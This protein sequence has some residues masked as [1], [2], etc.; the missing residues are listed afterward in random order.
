MSSR[1]CSHSVTFTTGG[2]DPDIGTVINGDVD[3]DFDAADDNDDEE[4]DD[5]DDETVIV[6]VAVGVD[7]TQPEDA[8]AAAAAVDDTLVTSDGDSLSPLITP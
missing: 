6:A 1:D 3:S 5:D 7:D 8:A 2:P 4:D